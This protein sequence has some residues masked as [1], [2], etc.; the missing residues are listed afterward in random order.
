VPASVDVGA[1]ADRLR[2]QRVHVSVRGT[3]IRVSPHV[4]N[5]ARDIE[6]LLDALRRARP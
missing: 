2:E 5:D 1:V 4:Y 3:A 6:A